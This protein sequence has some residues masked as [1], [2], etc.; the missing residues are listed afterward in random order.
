MQGLLSVVTF[1]KISTT[2]IIQR[3][4]DLSSAETMPNVATFL[5]LA[6]SGAAIASSAALGAYNVDPNSI[7]VSGL[8]SGGFMSAQLGV[9]YSDTFKVGFGVFAGGPYDC[10]RGQSVSHFS[11]I[12]ET[13]TFE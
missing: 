6:V 13:D 10:A 1:T 11:N 8:S 9:A 3:I 4:K 2:P 7:S 5:G 12:P